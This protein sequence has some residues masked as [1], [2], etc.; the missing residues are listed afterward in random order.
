MPEDVSVCGF[1]DNIYGRMCR[2]RITT[3]HQS[4]TEKGIRAV[5]AIREQ[6]EEN[7]ISNEWILMPVNLVEGDSVRDINED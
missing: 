6:I 7:N 1:D 5:T 3:I 2:P 4:P